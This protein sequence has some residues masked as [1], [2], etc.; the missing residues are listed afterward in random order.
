MTNMETFRDRLAFVMNQKDVRQADLVRRT[1]IKKST[2]SYYVTGRNLPNAENLHKIA[3]ALNVNEE[4]LLGYD[5]P[6]IR[7]PLSEDQAEQI[8]SRIRA[9]SKEHQKLILS[10]LQT[11]S[12]QEDSRKQ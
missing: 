7:S 3:V 5:A 8:L 12:D 9:L 10:F 1:G 4:W 6:M 2:I 11:L